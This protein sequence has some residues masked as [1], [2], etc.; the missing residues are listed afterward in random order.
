MTKRI[1]ATTKAMRR[2]CAVAGISDSATTGLWDVSGAIVATSVL[3]YL[4][5]CWTFAQYLLKG[6][7]TMSAVGP[8][9]YNA[10]RWNTGAVH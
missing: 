6:S 8:K 2:W 9:F 10:N 7:A 1:P 3:F 5:K 4:I